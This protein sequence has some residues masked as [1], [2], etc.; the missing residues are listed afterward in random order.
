MPAMFRAPIL[1]SPHVFD[2][3]L[4][5]G[6]RISALV[7]VSDLENRLRRARFIALIEVFNRFAGQEPAFRAC[8]TRFQR[9]SY[10]SRSVQRP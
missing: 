9:V 2:I 7:Y 4:S 10:V 1:N 3:A 8:K 5:Q 6:F